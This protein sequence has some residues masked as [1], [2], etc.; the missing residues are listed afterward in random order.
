MN[1]DKVAENV[2][3]K[4]RQLG[5]KLR[6]TDVALDDIDQ[7]R[8]SLYE[9]C[10][11]MLTDWQQKQGHD[12]TREILKQALLDI[13]MKNIVDTFFTDGADYSAESSPVVFS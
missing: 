5:R 13:G 10:M 4:W 3:R 2:G 8:D 12:A 6:V 11:S 9:K 1:L 7:R